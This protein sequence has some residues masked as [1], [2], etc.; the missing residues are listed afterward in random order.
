MVLSSCPF[1]FFK[2]GEENACSMLQESQL[3]AGF[4]PPVLPVFRP[5]KPRAAKPANGELPIPIFWKYSNMA[6]L[7]TSLPLR[8]TS[9]P[10]LNKY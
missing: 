4:R 5:P 2:T 10:T 1:E 7:H 8:Q 6:H 3:P 9:A